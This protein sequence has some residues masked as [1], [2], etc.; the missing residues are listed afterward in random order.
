MKAY[1]YKYAADAAIWNLGDG[2]QKMDYLK[3][4]LT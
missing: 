1:T 3:N 4:S 2:W